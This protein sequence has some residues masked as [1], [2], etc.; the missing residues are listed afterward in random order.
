MKKLIPCGNCGW[1]P[2]IRT[3]DGFFGEVYCINLEC[4]SEINVIYFNGSESDA[5]DRWND[6]QTGDKKQ[7]EL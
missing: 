1:S 5:I 7:N 3:K 2:V 4:N 6:Y